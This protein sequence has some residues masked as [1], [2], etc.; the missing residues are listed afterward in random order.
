MAKPIEYV[1]ELNEKRTREFLSVILNPRKNPER[2][3][4]IEKAKKLNIE[5]RD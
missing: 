2:D 1:T 4:L 5:V 3:I